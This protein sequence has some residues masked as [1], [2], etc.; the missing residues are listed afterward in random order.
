MGPSQDAF[1]CRFAPLRLPENQHAEVI[2][3]QTRQRYCRPRVVVEEMIRT[4][5][6]LASAFEE[7]VRMA[8]GEHRAD[9]QRQEPVQQPPAPPAS[10]D[11]VLNDPETELFLRFII[12]HPFHH[13]REIYATLGCSG[14]K[15]DKIKALLV[16]NEFAAEYESAGK[17]GRR[18]KL[19]LPTPNALAMLGVQVPSGK[20]GGVHRFVCGAVARLA[21]ARG[22]VPPSSTKGSTSSSSMAT[23][24]SPLRSQSPP[25][26]MTS[27]ETSGA[28]SPVGTAGS[29]SPV[30]TA[31]L[32]G[33]LRSSC[34]LSCRASNE[35]M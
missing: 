1:N 11:M 2:I 29:S 12:E 19:L 10:A 15:G 34:R 17:G 14:Y 18:A 31:R 32:W 9:D 33:R 27:C 5:L 22:T 35:P 30:L 20:G 7:A 8:E 21:E 28:H 16:R 4:G 23:N 6:P 25:G 13:I 3:E 24:H 26:P